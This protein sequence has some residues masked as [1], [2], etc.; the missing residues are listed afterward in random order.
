MQF[1]VEPRAV[2]QRLPEKTR[3]LAASEIP[4]LNPV[5][6]AAVDEKPEYG[7][8]IPSDLCLFYLGEVEASG[9]LV[10]DRN[11]SKSPVVGLW[12]VA[13]GE[14]PASRRDLAVQVLSNSGRLES[15]AQNAGLEAFRIRSSIGKVPPDLEGVSSGDDRYEI[16]I[17]KTQLVWDGRPAADSVAAE[18]PFTRRWMARGRRG[19]WLDG[20]IALSNN[21]TRAMIGSLKVEGKGDLAQMLK[22]SPV[23]FVGPAYEGG[24]GSFEFGR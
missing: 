15:A 10:R 6:R 16:R 21:W 20:R 12:M 17:G 24:R 11:A 9:R 5:L 22:A 7:S 4:D 1:L 2:S 23:R 8:W 14:A 18:A 19:G 3:L 13:A